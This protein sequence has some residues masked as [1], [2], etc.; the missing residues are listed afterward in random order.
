MAPRTIDAVMQTNE[1]LGELAV[2]VGRL[3]ERMAALDKASQERHENLE[4]SIDAQMVAVNKGLD[5]IKD[6]A[7]DVEGL[8]KYMNDYPTLVWLVRHRTKL[9]LMW[10]AFG[11][12]M[13][14]LVAAP[15][16]DRKVLAA[17][18][19]FAGVP[20]ALIEIIAGP[21]S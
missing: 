12:S 2:L 8:K 3:E 13:F 10:A 16:V 1:K 14:L 21:V 7:K 17:L 5:E 4:A 11:V 6:V 19:E 15:W 18:L 20:K 9:V